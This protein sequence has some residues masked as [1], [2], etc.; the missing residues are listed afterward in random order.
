MIDDIILG[1]NIIEEGSDYVKV[2]PKNPKYK[3]ISYSEKTIDNNIK[4]KYCYKIN[5]LFNVY[6]YKYIQ[7]NLSGSILPVGIRNVNVDVSNLTM[8]GEVFCK[9]ENNSTEHKKGTYTMGLIRHFLFGCPTDDSYYDWEDLPFDIDV[10]YIHKLVEDTTSTLLS[11][12]KKENLSVKDH[13]VLENISAN[14]SISVISF[15]FLKNLLT[16]FLNGSILTSNGFDVKIYYEFPP[17]EEKV[18]EKKINVK[19]L[20]PIYGNINVQW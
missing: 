1:Y 12:Y 6:C 14:W 16:I 7:G 13:S 3:I 9:I 4:K 11:N 20:L 17:G 2:K 5:G 15:D 10:D 8:S 18:I 19:L